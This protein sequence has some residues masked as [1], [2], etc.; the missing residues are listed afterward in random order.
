MSLEP[1]EFE[2]ANDGHLSTWKR[3]CGGFTYVS[4]FLVLVLALLAFALL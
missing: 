4:V 3:V 2:R 1:M